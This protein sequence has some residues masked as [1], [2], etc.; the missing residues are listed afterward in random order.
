MF[1]KNRNLPGTVREGAGPQIQQ[2]LTEV[3]S[4]LCQ[5]SPTSS[6]LG[7]TVPTPN[8]GQGSGGVHEPP[9]VCLHSQETDPVPASLPTYPQ[10]PAM[11]ALQ[12]GSEDFLLFASEPPTRL[13][14]DP[15]PQ[16][17]QGK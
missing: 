2:S 13:A 15:E 11:E 14:L 5:E 4:E 9:G 10:P 3:R 8:T 16:E 6:H 12:K 17:P 7:P 1:Q